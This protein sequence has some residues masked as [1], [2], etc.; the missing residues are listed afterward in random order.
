[1]TCSIWHAFLYIFEMSQKKPLAGELNQ[2]NADTKSDLENHN[3][4]KLRVTNIHGNGS[5]LI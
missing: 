2:P 1:M 5:E 3:F 4:V